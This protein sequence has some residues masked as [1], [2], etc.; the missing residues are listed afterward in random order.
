MRQRLHRTGQ[1]AD[2]AGEVYGTDIAG[3]G[4]AGA[5]ANHNS[6]HQ[7]HD[8]VLLEA[9]HLGLD[10]VE[11]L[12]ITFDHRIDLALIGTAIGAVFFVIALRIGLGRRDIA[13]QPC[14]FGAEGAELGG[15]GDH[16]IEGLHAALIDQRLP[17]GQQRIDAVEIGHDTFGERRS[18]FGVGR[19]ID[20]PG[21]H[22]HRRHVA[23][24]PFPEIGPIGQVL[25]AAGLLVVFHHHIAS[26]AANDDRGQTHQPHNG[27]NFGANIHVTLHSG[28]DPPDMSVMSSA[29]STL[30]DEVCRG[31]QADVSLSDWAAWTVPTP[32]GGSSDLPFTE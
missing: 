12:E 14:G 22:H 10:P 6:A 23:V 26:H 28:R 9:A 17:F 25:E 3:H 16:G 18:L 7:Q 15:A 19:G 24:E 30:S 8:H 4:D 5:Q 13:A 11:Q 31:R 27:K 20:A 1:P 29:N 32:V 2:R 21:L